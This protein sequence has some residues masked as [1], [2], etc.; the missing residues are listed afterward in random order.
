MKHGENYTKVHYKLFK[1]TEKET[2]VKAARKK[3]MLYTEE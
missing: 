2:I 1:I 3:K